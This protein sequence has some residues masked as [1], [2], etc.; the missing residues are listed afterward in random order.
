MDWSTLSFAKVAA[1]A[2]L[3]ISNETL[4]LILGQSINSWRNQ[5]A[6]SNARNDGLQRPMSSE[7]QQLKNVRRT[8]ISKHGNVT[9][10]VEA[11][12]GSISNSNALSTGR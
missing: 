9:V 4:Q 8:R 1:V 2:W 3:A 5:T 11:K 7:V 10:H 6:I 12:H